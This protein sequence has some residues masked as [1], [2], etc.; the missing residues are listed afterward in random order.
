MAGIQIFCTEID[1]RMDSVPDRK[2]DTMKK[3][4]IGD[5]DVDDSHRKALLSLQQFDFP[6]LQLLNL[7]YRNREPLFQ[8]I[9]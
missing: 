5:I 2:I 3:H 4:G 7:L 6:N 9:F 1:F 8:N